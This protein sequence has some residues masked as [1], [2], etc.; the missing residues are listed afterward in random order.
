MPFAPS[1]RPV[2]QERAHHGEPRFAHGNGFVLARVL[3]IADVEKLVAHILVLAAACRP[4]GSRSRVVRASKMVRGASGVTV[5]GTPLKVVQA[6]VGFGEDRL[7]RAEAELMPHIGSKK[8]QRARTQVIRQAVVGIDLGQ[9]RGGRCSA[10]RHAHIGRA[11]FF[12][13]HQLLGVR[14]LERRSAGWRSGRG[15][16]L[17]R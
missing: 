13:E 16:G 5:P 17:P 10:Q 2:V 9:R 1:S 11:R 6:R 12:V 7:H 3:V 4:S 15:G 8:L 14:A